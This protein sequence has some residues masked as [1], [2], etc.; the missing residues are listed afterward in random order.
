MLPSGVQA[1]PN[2]WLDGKQRSIKNLSSSLTFPVTLSSSFLQAAR[3]ISCG[4]K[5]DKVCRTPT[6]V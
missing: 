2:I 1:H 5:N 4:V 6:G 3:P